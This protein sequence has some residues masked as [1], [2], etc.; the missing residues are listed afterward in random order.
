L[1]PYSDERKFSV[2]S[3][4]PLKIKLAALLEQQPMRSV[5][6]PQPWD[7][8][9]LE[10]CVLIVEDFVRNNA[11]GV[12]NDEDPLSDWLDSWRLYQATTPTKPKAD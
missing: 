6:P 5:F 7:D 2:K 3:P 1:F 11:L 9:D 4:N 10:E 8:A 12:V